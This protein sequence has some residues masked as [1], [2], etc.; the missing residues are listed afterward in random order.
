MH[1]YDS[2]G[3][4]GADTANEIVG[5]EIGRNR[6]HGGDNTGYLTACQERIAQACDLGFHI[7]APGKDSHDE[8]PYHRPLYRQQI[9]RFGEISHFA[10]QLSFFSDVWSS[11]RFSG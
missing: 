9:S 11:D 8:Y 5:V 6:G 7:Y 3:V 2:D 4:C 1:E 10:P